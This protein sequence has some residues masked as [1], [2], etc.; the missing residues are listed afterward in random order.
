MKIMSY[1][2]NKIFYILF[3][4]STIIVLALLLGFAE[5]PFIYIVLIIVILLFILISPLIP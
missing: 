2:E 3:Q 1:L 4:V 5:I